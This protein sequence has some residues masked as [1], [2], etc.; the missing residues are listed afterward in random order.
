MSRIGKLPIPIPAG[1]TVDISGG[2]VTV[3]G[4]KGQ[5]TR[6]I[7]AEMRVSIE[8]NN[9]IVT[10]SSDDN[11]H[12][13]YHGLT[14]SLLAN[15]VQ[16]VSKGF[17]KTLDI[18][19]VGYRAEKTGDKLTL[20]L[21]FSSQV[22]VKPMPGITLGVEGTNKIKVSG[23]NKEDVGQMAAEIRALR[24]PD[25]FKGKGIRYTGERVRIKPGKA[26]KVV[27]RQ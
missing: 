4:P 16:G 19:G 1:V 11:K 12:R 20:R 13:A 25:H 26:G 27:S 8:G 14:R 22:E 5:L 6:S 17:E 9:L 23:I 21:G 7:P 24:V 10:R 2:S 15:M 18:V 3:K